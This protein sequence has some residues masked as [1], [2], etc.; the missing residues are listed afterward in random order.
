M[1]P[2]LCIAIV[3]NH[4]HSTIMKLKALAILGAI[5]GSLALL[6]E[7]MPTPTPYEPTDNPAQRVR[8]FLQGDRSTLDDADLFAPSVPEPLRKAAQQL[9]D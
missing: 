1:K 3:T 4:Y 8:E 5:I 6:P 7:D 9:I 2:H